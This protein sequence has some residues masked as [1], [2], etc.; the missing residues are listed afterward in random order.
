MEIDANRA[1]TGASLKVEGGP[2]G[3]IRGE[4]GRYSGR[5]RKAA[6]EEWTIVKLDG[7]DLAAGLPGLL[8]LTLP[9]KAG[10]ELKLTELTLGGPPAKAG[11]V[12]LTGGT[13][14]TVVPEGIKLGAWR[15]EAK[16]DGTPTIVWVL[17]DGVIAQV[18][19]GGGSRLLLSSEPTGELF[20]PQEAAVTDVSK[21]AG[22]LV[23]Q[24]DFPGFTT[25][26]MFEHWTKA[27]LVKKWWAPEAEVGTGVGGAYIL[28]WPAQKWTLRGEILAWEPGKKFG[29]T[30]KW[31]HEPKQ[32]AELR[33]SVE[34][35]ALEGGTRLT[36]THG[37]YDGSA[38]SKEERNGHLEGWKFF[39]AQLKALKAK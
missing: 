31:D 28:K 29:Y 12:V 8:A 7:A 23:V 14:D 33:V 26:E 17:E 4:G 20:Q 10:S 2:E 25:A 22:A 36:I 16:R 1:L 30:W 6:G 37:P 21:D 13:L 9:R 39:C 3:E 18:E 11:P 38:E 32:K 19:W 35:G 27:E 24:G 15:F 34:I 5:G